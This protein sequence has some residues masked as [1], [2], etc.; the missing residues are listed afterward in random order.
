MR[1][2][3]KRTTLAGSERT[4]L[5]SAKAV[6]KSD[7]TERVEVTIMLRPR[8][9]AATGAARAL[10]VE[11]GMHGAHGTL[12]PGPVVVASDASR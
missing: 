2:S 4:I 11:P 3:K 8:A 10:R 7:P 1:T 5:N 12:H 6:G 9:S